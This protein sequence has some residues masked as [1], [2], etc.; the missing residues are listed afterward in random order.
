MDLVPILS[1]FENVSTENALYLVA[2]LFTIGDAPF[3][4]TENE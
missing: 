4:E 1:V 2:A 3:I